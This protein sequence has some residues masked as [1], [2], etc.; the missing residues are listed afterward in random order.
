MPAASEYN[1]TF[2][3]RQQDSYWAVVS[4]LVSLI[5]RTR[6]HRQST[7]QQMYEIE[8]DALGGRMSPKRSTNVAWSDCNQHLR[9]A[10]LILLAARPA[11]CGG[12]DRVATN[13]ALSSAVTAAA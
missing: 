13:E 3:D 9:E 4:D 7:D 10:L 8:G 6:T 11:M 1:V 5:E 12:R 2:G